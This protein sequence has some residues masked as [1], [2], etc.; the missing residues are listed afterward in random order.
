MFEAETTEGYKICLRN[1]LVIN[2]LWAWMGAM[3][4]SPIEGIVSPAYNVYIPARCLDPG[5]VDVYGPYA[6]VCRGSHAILKRSLVFKTP[7][8]S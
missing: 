6:S 7:P 1:D 3:G 8:L 5:Y 2:T 4:V